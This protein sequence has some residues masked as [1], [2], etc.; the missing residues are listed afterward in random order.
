M[1]PFATKTQGQ[2]SSQEAYTLWDMLTSRYATVEKIQIFQNFIHDI[3][4]KL[5]V[6]SSLNTVEKEINELEKTM[7]NFGI[8]LPR[9]PPKSVRT[10][11]NT[12]AIED[13]FTAGLFTGMLQENI[14]SYLR[15]FRTSLTNDGIRNIFVKYMRNEVELYD[16]AIKY[17]KLKGW[18]GNP[19]LYPQSPAGTTE[20]LDTGEA[21]HIWDHLSSRYDSIEITHIYQSLAHDPDFSTVLLLG[22]EKILTKQIHILEKEMDHFGLP[23]PQRPPKTAPLTAQQTIFEDELLYRQIF[24]GMQFMLEL[25]ATAFR[26]NITND[27]LRKIYIDFLHEEVPLI[28]K[29]IKYGKAKGW[30]RANPSYKVNT[31]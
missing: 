20:K 18:L 3:D 15:A 24:T 21:F 1:W 4:Y 19:P 12:E 28:N 14:S 31:Q 10:P 13:R 22:T 6:V 29:W 2:L 30:L 17:F 5:L 11:A 8:A 23:L 27:R 26:Q 7:N 16:N 9:R 25:H